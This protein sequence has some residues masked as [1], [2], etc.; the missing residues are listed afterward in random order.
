MSV[1]ENS[2]SNAFIAISSSAKFLEMQFF[3]FE[4]VVSE[5]LSTF[6][7]IGGLSIMLLFESTL[8]QGF[9]ENP[10]TYQNYQVI[11]KKMYERDLKTILLDEKNYIEASNS[12]K[13][14]V[15]RFTNNFT[16]R[17]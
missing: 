2:D 4:F 8:H 14:L 6:T 11:E 7:S 17:Y 5:E 1:E 10:G 12:Y 15:N 3:W 13:F 16:T 9:Y